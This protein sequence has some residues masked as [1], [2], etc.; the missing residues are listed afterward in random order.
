[1]A[2]LFR[3]FGSSIASAARGL[4]GKRGTSGSP[5]ATEKRLEKL[6]AQEGQLQSQ[7][8]SARDKRERENK[9][10]AQ[11]TI[12]R[13]LAQIKEQREKLE[14]DRKRQDE[15]KRQNDPEYRFVQLGEGVDTPQSSN[16]AHIQY[17]IKDDLLVIRFKDGST[18]GYE[19]IFPQEA[20][21][22]FKSASKGTW[23]WDNLRIRGTSLGHKKHYYLIIGDRKWDKNR[24]VA[25]AHAA[26]ASRQSGMKKGDVFHPYELKLPVTNKG[27]QAKRAPRGR[28]MDNT[29]GS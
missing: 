7:A 12:D 21:S 1:M 13:R 24:D 19:P 2:G 10:A 22:L 9:T 29:G 11:E 23:V 26:E 14:R 5:S 25:A 28:N 3:K 20:A 6:K 17:A 18:Y 15:D 4:F 27:R 16:V 8:A